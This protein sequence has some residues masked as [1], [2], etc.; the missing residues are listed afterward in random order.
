MDSGSVDVPDLANMVEGQADAAVRMA[1]VQTADGWQIM[2]AEVTLSGPRPAQARTWR[3]ADEILLERLLPGPAV[4][5][6]LRGDVQDLDGLAV[7]APAPPPNCTFQRL[8]GHSRWRHVVLPWPRTEWEVSRPESM[9][10]RN[11]GVRVGDGPPFVNFEAAFSS[12]FYG[13]LPTN[14]AGQQ[15]LWRIL[16]V[17]Q[18]AWLHRVTIGPDAMTV[19]VRGASIDD[20]VLELSTPTGHL[21]RAVGRT[22]KLRV[23][24]TQ[25]ADPQQPATTSP[26][27]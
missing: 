22:G 13:A 16:R 18:R 4:A 5:S 2:H 25:R 7:F 27:R 1:L 23:P 8:A 9:V 14:M 17:D 12:F 11:G 20:V 6:L 21:T 19:M 24:A 3:Y 26:R 10:N 15:P